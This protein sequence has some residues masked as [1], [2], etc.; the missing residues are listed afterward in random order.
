MK[1]RGFESPY[2]T[3]INLGFAAATVNNMLGETATRIRFDHLERICH[4]LNC[5]PNDLFE[6][7]PPEGMANPQE[8]SLIKLKREHEEDMRKLLYNIPIEKFDEIIDII[9]NLKDK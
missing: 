8:R 6:W 5:T 1:L 3:L 7:I 2:K 9:H 4:L